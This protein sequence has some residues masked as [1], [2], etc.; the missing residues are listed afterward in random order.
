MGAVSCILNH[1][2]L[3]HAEGDPALATELSPET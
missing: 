2:I 1:I 3:S